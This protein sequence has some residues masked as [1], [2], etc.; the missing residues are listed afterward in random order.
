[1]AGASIS[2]EYEAGKALTFLRRLGEHIDDLSPLFGQIGDHLIE[3]TQ[4]RFAAQQAPD[5]TPWAPLSPAYARRKKKNADKI[6][7]LD[8]ILRDTLAYNA[9]PRELEF[10]T[11]RIYGAIHQFGGKIQHAARSQQAYFRQDGRT[12]LVGNRFVSKSRSN[13]AQWV[14][15]GAHTTEIPARPFLG[16]SAEDENEIL[17][18]LRDYVADEL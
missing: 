2:I 7:V 14:T 4:D 13:F 1:M 6:L 12:G 3:S 5:G 16:I 18:L 10:G 8:A 15:I 9:G 17:K 11:N